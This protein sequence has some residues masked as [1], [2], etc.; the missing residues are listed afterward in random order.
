MPNVEVNNRFSS[1]EEKS[2]EKHVHVGKYK[3]D[4]DIA[5]TK[6]ALILG[7][8]HI[9][10][11]KT[12]NF[13]PGWLVH[14]YTRYS[15]AEM[16]SKMLEVDTDYDCIFFHVFTND[17]KNKTPELFTQRFEIFCQNLNITVNLLNWSYLSPFWLKDLE[18]NQKISQ[19]NVLLL[20]Y[21]FLRSSKIEMSEY[22]VYSIRNVFTSD[23]LHLSREGTSLFVANI[24]YWLRKTLNN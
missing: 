9:R 15:M 24:K 13:L 20:Q 12:D 5:P 17:I 19:C 2:P 21:N 10:Y 16:E 3:Q 11:F 22:S 4:H 18:L 6:K 23:G 7:N 14:R 8:S 1:L